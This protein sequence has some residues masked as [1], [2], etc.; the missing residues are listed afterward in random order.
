[1]I[2]QTS[3]LSFIDLPPTEELKLRI[4]DCL[5]K[6]KGGLTD[7][8]IMAEIGQQWDKLEPR[9][10]RHELA[11]EGRIAY[12]KQRKCKVSGRAAMVWVL[13]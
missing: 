9:V 13:K 12:F 1:M 6:H 2:Q 11:K 3:I 7:S 5:A 10:R 4:L 8:E